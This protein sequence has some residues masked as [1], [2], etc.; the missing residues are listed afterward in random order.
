MLSVVASTLTRRLR[1]SSPW[2]SDQIFVAARQR[3]TG[4]VSMGTASCAAGPS[5]PAPAL[6]SGQSAAPTGS[7]NATPALT[8]HGYL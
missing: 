5:V 6:S 3:Q 7:A 8:Q 4:R 1:T 2:R